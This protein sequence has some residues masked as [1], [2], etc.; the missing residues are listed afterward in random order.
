MKNNWERYYEMTRARPPREI[1][2]RAVALVKERRVAIDM[3]AGALS[4][5]LFLHQ[6]GFEKVIALDAEEAVARRARFL[7][8]AYHIEER[9]FE[10]VVSRMEDFHF[11]IS[12]Y[13]LV[14]AQFSLPFVRPDFFQSVWHSISDSL[15]NGG[16]V[17]GQL[18]G[19]RDEWHTNPD[20]TFHTRE[21]AKR[22]Y[23]GYI[24]HEFE[25]YERMGSTALGKEK[26]WHYFELI[27]EKQESGRA[28]DD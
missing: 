25:E 10:S 12:H 15:L 8:E 26:H 17:V 23:E 22:L 19:N 28:Y 13:S 6:S 3:G 21:E 24:I 9:Q 20:L 1:L 27:L 7:R 4:D 2:K 11:P 14:S 18:F 5:T 16:I